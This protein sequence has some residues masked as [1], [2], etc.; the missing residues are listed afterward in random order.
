[1]CGAT[2]QRNGEPA[3]VYREVDPW[4]PAEIDRFLDSVA[5]DRYGPLYAFAIGSGC[6]QGEILGLRW[7]DFDPE[8][9]TVRIAG[10]LSRRRERAEVKTERGRRTFGLP[11]LALFALKAQRVQQARDRLA[12]G[13]GWEDHGGYVFTM[14]DGRPGGWRSL[15]AAFVR[16]QARAGVR[17]QRFHDMCHA[18]ATLCS[19]RA[20]AR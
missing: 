2:L 7:D 13:S 12:A 14:R 1:L 16:A 10:Q 20:R 19:T 6:R 11:E 15:D 5:G 8:A 4:T 9:G 17:R 3:A 18:F